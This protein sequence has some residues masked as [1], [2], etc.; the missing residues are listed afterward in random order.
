M[1]HLG[2]STHRKLLIDASDSFQANNSLLTCPR[3]FRSRSQQ[4]MM[5]DPQ[6]GD[7]VFDLLALASNKGFVLDSYEDDAVG[8]LEKNAGGKFAVTHIELRP[9]IQ[10]GGV[11]QPTQADLDWLPDKAHRECFIANSV[12]TE[13]RV[14]LAQ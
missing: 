10:S 11:N 4:K 8:R 3:P 6:T 5:A 1:I 12:T 9:R 14:L 2:G 7:A 13:V